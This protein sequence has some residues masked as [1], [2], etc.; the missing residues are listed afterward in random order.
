MNDVLDLLDRLLVY[1]SMLA[2]DLDGLQSKSWGE[3]IFFAVLDE[4]F[5]DIDE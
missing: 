4:N 5:L 3:V 2:F 1:L